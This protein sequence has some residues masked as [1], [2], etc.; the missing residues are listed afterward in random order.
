VWLWRGRRAE[1]V[2][3][4]S[5]AVE[6]FFHIRPPFVWIAIVERFLTGLAGIPP[7]LRFWIGS[8]FCHISRKTFSYVFKVAE[9]IMCAVRH[10][11]EI[12]RKVPDVAVVDHAQHSRPYGSVQALVF[13]DFFWFYPDNASLSFHFIF[14]IG[15]IFYRGSHEV[16][17]SASGAAAAIFFLVAPR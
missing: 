11:A 16:C 4:G 14:L 2:G 3:V 12:N 8:H 13:V 5:I 1:S 9:E 17:Q 15:Q 10:P 7:A 6:N